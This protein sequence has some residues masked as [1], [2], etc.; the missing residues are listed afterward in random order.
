LG[1]RYNPVRYR[2]ESSG[3]RL[4]HQLED[5]ID[6][7]KDRAT[8][9]S[10]NLAGDDPERITLAEIAST[11]RGPRRKKEVKFTGPRPNLRD[12]PARQARASAG[13]A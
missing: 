7:R 12:T 11:S 10:S 1:V 8:V 4:R 13:A 5:N 2:R 9:D 6:P 3:I